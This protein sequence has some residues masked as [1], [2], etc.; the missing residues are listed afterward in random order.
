LIPHIYDTERMVQVV[1]EDGKIQTITI[2]KSMAS[3]AGDEPDELL[4]DYGAPP[5]RGAPIEGA[6]EE[7]VEEEGEALNDRAPVSA[8]SKPDGVVLN[9]VTVGAYGIVVETG[10]S[11]STRREEA[12]AGMN[13]F[14]Q[15]FPA[16]GPLILDL[17]AKAQDWP[18]AGEIA[19][20]AEMILPPPVQALLAREKA[21]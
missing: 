20:R 13:Q 14:V 4:D 8:T 21:G 1:G 3:V 15:A 5:Q 7:V 2:N 11:Y 10:P 9:D 12:R 6:I 18:F 19:R 17:L 16:A